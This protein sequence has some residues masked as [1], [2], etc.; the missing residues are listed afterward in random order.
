M[1][2]ESIHPGLSNLLV[3]L[4]V[5][6]SP[7]SFERGVYTG[8]FGQNGFKSLDPTN[9]EIWTGHHIDKTAFNKHLQQHALAAGVIV[10]TDSVTQIHAQ[11]T[12][13]DTVTCQSGKSYQA[14]FILDCSGRSQ[15]A[16]K[17]LKL[18]K[19]YYSPP[20][21]AWTGVA[22]AGEKIADQ[23]EPSFLPKQDHWEWIAPE[24]GNNF[25]WTQVA[26][27]GWTDFSPPESLK[28]LPLTGSIDVYNVRWRLFRPTAVNGLL[29]CGDAAALIDPASS[30]GILSAVMSAIMAVTAIKN[31]IDAP[32][33]E[34]FIYAGYDQ[35]LTDQFESRASKLEAYYRELLP[36]WFPT[37]RRSWR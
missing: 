26:Q 35:W 15:V 3:S 24:K 2:S 32:H 28:G 10:V 37:D 11:S 23:S 33:L 9:N 19:R 5:D 29:L 18:K 25:T 34:Q 20:L 8:I 36:A 31:I 13:T 14:G 16:G 1:A 6:M 21:V 17:L 27:K 4:G 30:Q 7:A 12:R 22:D